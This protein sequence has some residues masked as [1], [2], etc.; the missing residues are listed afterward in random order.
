MDCNYSKNLK[1]DRVCG[2]CKQCQCIQCL[3]Y[4]MKRRKILYICANEYDFFVNKANV[5]GVGLGYKTS[6]G[7]FTLKECI[8]VFVSE[9][10]PSNDIPYEDLIP[11]TYKGIET[12]VMETGIFASQSL[13]GKIRPV[14]GGCSIGPKGRTTLGTVACLVTDGTD[15]FIL[16]NN[17]VLADENIVPIG[18]PILQPA[19]EDKGK[20]PEDVV[21]HLSKFVPLKFETAKTKPTN[22]VDCAMAKIVNDTVA[23][24]EI[25]GIGYPKGIGMPKLDENVELVGRTSGKV[26]G[27]II[28]LGSTIEIQYDRGKALLVNQI[29]TTDMSKGG[30]SGALLLDTNRHALGLLSSGTQ[31]YSTFNLIDNVVDELQVDIVTK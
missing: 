31:A 7:M 22:F 11:A 2:L 20:Y 1:C 16:S 25:K 28:S 21:A 6:R 30:D 24:G 18:T 8:L 29:L 3:N 13:K 12:D 4:C 5:V 10:I 17:H 14:V 26:K 15:K 23:T 27:T 9:K 19:P